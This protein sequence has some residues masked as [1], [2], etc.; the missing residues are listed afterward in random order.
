M[1]NRRV[2]MV[3]TC[4]KSRLEY[5]GCTPGFDCVDPYNSP[6]PNQVEG[7][8]CTSYPSC[9]ACPLGMLDRSRPDRVAWAIHVAN[10]IETS[11][12]GIEHG[13]YQ[14]FYKPIV[15]AVRDKWLVRLSP[16]F[17]REAH[18]LSTGL[19]RLAEFE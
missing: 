14:V 2:R 17:L 12:D 18:T 9:P 11:K 6:L 15:D 3:R 1:T 16:A 19:P 13:R 7:E 4:G 5:T 10:G 8:M